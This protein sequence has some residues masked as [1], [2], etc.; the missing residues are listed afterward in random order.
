MLKTG[1][2]FKPEKLVSLYDKY[3][4]ITFLV[5]FLP[6]I[7][8]SFVP[9]CTGGAVV[10]A[11]FFTIFGFT[12]WWIRAFYETSFYRLTQDDIEHKRGVWFKSKTEVPYNRITNVDTNQGPVQRYVGC[13]QVKIQTA[14]S[15]AQTGAELII[16]GVEN[17]EEIQEQIVM[18][19]KSK[20]SSSAV[21]S[22]EE[23]EDGENKLGSILKEVR[24]I[25]EKL[26]EE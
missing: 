8:I 10:S 13:G 7:A 19:V 6:L 1:E 11:I 9:S 12:F 26:E 4:Y 25:R 15:S 22:F 23:E 18:K 5:V 16:N 2:W 20:K 3:L 21:E 14:G 24:K 17:F